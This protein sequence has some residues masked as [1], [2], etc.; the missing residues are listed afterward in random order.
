MK[1]LYCTLIIAIYCMNGLYAQ[2][3]YTGIV[4]DKNNGKPLDVVSVSLLAADSSIINYSHTNEQGRFEVKPASQGVF[5]S[6][7]SIAYKRQ[8][9]PVG[10]FVNGM[11]IRLE[12]SIVQIREVKVTSQR[13]RQTK[14]TLTYSVSGFKMPQD[15]SIEDV[16]KK[17]PGIEVTPNG[18]IKF[19]DKPIS[20][21]YIDGMN[22][23]EDRY[24][25]G[26]KNIPADMVKEVQVLQAHQPIAALRGKSFSDNAALNLTLSDKAKSRLIKLI[27]LSMGA[28][29]GYGAL[30]DNRLLGMMFGHKMQNLTMYK[31]NNTG[32]DI[33][34]EIVPLAQNGV[35]NMASGNKEE[36][37]FSPSASKAGNVDPER[38]LFNQS[39][40]AAVN[41]LYRP[42]T[43]T[44]LRLQ[45]TALHTE[46]TSDHQSGTTYFYPSQTI[47]V[48]EK[49]H[50]AAQENRAE[51]ELTYQLNDSSIYLKNTLKGEI[52]LHK[53]NLELDVDGQRINEHIHPQQKF[54]QNNFELIKN[55]RKNA[56]SIYSCNTYTELPQYMTV[57]PGLYEELLSGGTSYNSF[58][59]MAR[60]SAFQSD[61][62]TYFQHKL[63][64]F[65]LKYKT[66]VMY[67]NKLLTSD[68]YTDNR[69]V[70]DP[71]FANDLRMESVKLYIEPSFNYKNSFWNIQ[72]SIPLSFLRLNLKY[73][74]PEAKKVVEKRL[75]PMPEVNIRYEIDAYWTATLLSSFS[76]IE[77]DIRELYT[78]Y[79]FSSY[80]SASAYTSLPSYDKNWYNMLG[81]R[82]NNP[83]TGFFL[84]MT[85]FYNLSRRD[86]VYSYENVN[87]FFTLCEATPL[88]YNN[89]YWGAR[90]RLS[91]AYAWS[92]LFT[93]LSAGYTQN[94]SQAL[95]EEELTTSS[96]KTINLKFDFSL[97]PDRCINIDGSSAATHIIS[98]LDYAGSEVVKTWSYRHELNLNFIVTPQ[99]KVRLANTLSH[100]NRNRVL[101]Y[102]ADAS[103]SYSHR[104]FDIELKGRNLFNRSRIDNV[105]VS[106]LTEQYTSHTLRPQEFLIKVMF[107]F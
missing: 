18:T 100:D 16:L 77:P 68:I 11:N 104:L 3:V 57:T 41:H 74:E 87:G 79:L 95:L 80:R 52:G 61:T 47:T 99:W 65:Y 51:G 75:I 48:S 21:F 22:L 12:E 84:S 59:Q 60:L 8:I 67:K 54:L 29:N 20:Q 38:Y 30:W 39:H 94:K 88:K 46:E 64:G 55:M 101:T 96:L 40:L 53:S 10:Q 13:I 36:N 56:L 14:D 7:T 24:A 45:L 15:R 31:N 98:S 32:R 83:L 1:L 93:A 26:S 62:Y 78:G 63:A 27:D 23:L 37:L 35:I 44:D 58:R 91:K 4:T 5:L 70:E 81:V 28:G 25:L 102:F 6:F 34:S 107:S 72:A 92:K 49:E 2:S 17:I 76:Y 33:A 89:H 103:I 90:G 82:F 43:K 9:L 69:P 85:G 19:Q 73:K 42:N 97:Q 50:Y 105:Y 71:S 66:G 86:V 106:S